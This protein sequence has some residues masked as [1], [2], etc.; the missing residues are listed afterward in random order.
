MRTVCL[1][2]IS[3]IAILGAVT[4]FQDSPVLGA[5][6]G[7]K[8]CNTSPRTCQASYGNTYHYYEI[9]VNQ[10]PS[11]V[12]QSSYWSVAFAN[13]KSSW[14]GSSGPQIMV[15]P[16]GHAPGYPYTSVWLY[17]YPNWS[18]PN[19]TW[20]MWLQASGGLTVPVDSSGIPCT[21]LSSPCNV[22][23]A[24]IWVNADRVFSKPLQQQPWYTQWIMAHELGHVQA[25]AHYP[26]QTL[27]V[28]DAL[29]VS[30]PRWN[31][32]N[33]SASSP[34]GPVLK[35]IGTSPPCVEGMNPYT[36]IRCIYNW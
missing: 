4:L 21:S 2:F 1:G 24:D 3:V 9:A 15:G 25:L 34:N 22:W 16:G 32:G 28:D 29:M 5:S 30:A 26:T 13:A 10:C 31:T 18:P 27:P 8:R 23:W 6:M 11:C 33:H 36:T 17:Q 35:D 19:P 20:E 7:N 12:D 14:T